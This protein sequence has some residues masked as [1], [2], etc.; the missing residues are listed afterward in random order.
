[1]QH[2]GAGGGEDAACATAG[3]MNGPVG[4]L[5]CIFFNATVFVLMCFCAAA[6]SIYLFAPEAGNREKHV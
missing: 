5:Y 2:A 4:L 1:M 3:E 6:S